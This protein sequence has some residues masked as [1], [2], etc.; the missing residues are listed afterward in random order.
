MTSPID[1]D[2]PLPLLGGL[3]PARF[4]QRHWHKKPLLVRQAWPADAPPVSRAQMFKM[5]AGEQVESRLIV[6]QAGKRGVESGWSL[7]HGP[8]PRRALPPLAQPGWT[9]LLQGL[10]LHWP[11]ARQLLEHFRFVPDAR[12]DDVMVS[13]ASDGGGVGPHFDSYDVFLLQTQG[14]R[15][16]RIGRLRNPQL[17][18][19]LP[20]KI[21][22]NFEPEHEWDLQAGDMLYLPPGWA[23]DGVAVGGDCMTCSIGFR[24]P[25][26]NELVAEVL[27]RIAEL[28][29]LDESPLYKDPHQPATAHPAELPGELMDWG[30]AAVRA[31]LEKDEA[32]TL[33]LGESLS[34]P[35]PSVQFA[36][37]ADALGD[38]GVRLDPG[39][40]M[41]Y[42]TRHVYVNGASWRMG[43]QDAKRLR[44]LADRRHLD[45]AQVA[46]A[47]PAL[48]EWL[49]E[50]LEEGW[51]HPGVPD[52]GD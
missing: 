2:Q 13:Y 47:S 10:D 27:T 5:I 3:S 9:A 49:Q 19:G 6:K 14:C 23:H 16:W 21:L 40:R 46:A 12:L 51:L 18:D 50:A 28:Q 7:K 20:L 35:K 45:A 34:E 22:A 44:Q 32:I 1:L 31:A 38:Q 26:R 4:M 39:T 48:Q 36:P 11:P 15:R 30:V 42:D 43:G 25:V 8:L 24:S 33:A 17:V 29:D 41:L 37:S 52:Q